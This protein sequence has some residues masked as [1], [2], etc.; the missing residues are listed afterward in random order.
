LCLIIYHF[1]L[2]KLK[3]SQAARLE[4]LTVTPDAI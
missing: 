1:Y 4:K 3:L 2:H